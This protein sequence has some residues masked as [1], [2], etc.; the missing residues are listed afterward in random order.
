MDLLNAWLF[1]THSEVTLRAW[2]RRLHLFRFC[3]AYG[4]QANDGDSLQ[5]VYSYQQFE[6]L[7]KFLGHLG[8]KL[9]T[10]DEQPPQSKEG[11]LYSVE[12]FARIPS[13]IPGTQW[14]EQPGY[15]SVAGQKA[16]IWCEQ[17]S[18]RIS[19]GEGYRVTEFE[20]QAAEQ[21]ENA[22]VGVSLARVD[23]PV[24]HKRCICPKYYPHYF[25]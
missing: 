22:L 6:E 25:G 4:G 1:E 8:I 15:C 20:V 17:D 11:V 21:I 13:L 14:I 9:A 2:A 24:D 10:F 23:P 16:L 5:V 18:I 3:R 19:V 7:D 12:D